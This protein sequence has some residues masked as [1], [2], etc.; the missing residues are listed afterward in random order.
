MSRAI[1]APAHLSHPRPA[2]APASSRRRASDID[3]GSPLATHYKWLFL[4]LVAGF[5]TVPLLATLLGGFKSL[6]ELRT[7][8]FG[9]PRKRRAA[10]PASD[11]RTCCTS[12]CS[13]ASPSW[14]A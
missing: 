1:E 11:P 8:P 2:G 6:G 12:A 13:S 14:S 5:V 3:G 4:L 7:N 9:I 10:P